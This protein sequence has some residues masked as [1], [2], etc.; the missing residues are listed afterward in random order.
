[1]RQIWKAKPSGKRNRSRSTKQ[2]N[3]QI[4]EVLKEGNINKRK[5]QQLAADEELWRAVE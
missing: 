1:M 2:S 5:A 4:N 3:K